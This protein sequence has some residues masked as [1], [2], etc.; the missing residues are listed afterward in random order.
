MDLEGSGGQ[1]HFMQPGMQVP[2]NFVEHSRMFY[3]H[4]CYMVSLWIYV[5][6]DEASSNRV[7]T[8]MLFPRHLLLNK[9]SPGQ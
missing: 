2:M 6:M 5:A 3:R 1:L 8:K 9:E 7:F 4:L